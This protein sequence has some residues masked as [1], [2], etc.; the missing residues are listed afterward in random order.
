MRARMEPALLEI[1]LAEYY[2]LQS[3]TERLRT[4]GLSEDTINQLIALRIV[5]TLS[6]ISVLLHQLLER[7]NEAANTPQTTA[8]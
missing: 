5:K 2:K 1:E 8:G 6:D 7:K 3:I 4:N